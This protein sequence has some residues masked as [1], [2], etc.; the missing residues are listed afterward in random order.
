L[1]GSYLRLL[2]YFKNEFS[3]QSAVNV[4]S[5]SPYGPFAQ[6]ACVSALIS[7]LH[8]DGDRAVFR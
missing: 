6:I 4:F 1:A 7:G 5:L 8:R 3:I 2:D